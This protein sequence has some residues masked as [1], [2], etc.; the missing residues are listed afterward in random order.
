[1]KI[2]KNLVGRIVEITWRD[3]HT[4]DRMSRRS[5]PRGYEAL[6]T[7]TEYGVVDDITDGIIRL[8]HSKAVNPPYEGTPQEEI[9]PSY[10]H[11]ALVEKIQVLEPVP[12]LTTHN[13]GDSGTT[14]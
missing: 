3:P 12:P 4:G 5:A 13:G 11:E 6:A 14:L 2:P 10:I 9:V 8:Y 7:W 1:M